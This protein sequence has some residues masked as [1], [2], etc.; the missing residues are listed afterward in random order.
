MSPF[1]WFTVKIYDTLKSKL[2]PST[3]E[4]ISDE[5]LCE[6]A[7][8]AAHEYQY[9]Q[10]QRMTGAEWRAIRMA[11]SLACDLW[12]ERRARLAEEPP[13]E[14]INLSDTRYLVLE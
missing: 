10:I 8:M 2:A 1:I 13:I 5:K 14:H 9:T 3:L 4:K 11:V 7:F 6:V 12:D